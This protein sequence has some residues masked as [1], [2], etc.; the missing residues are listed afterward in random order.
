MFFN[1]NIFSFS[2][3]VCEF[4]NKLLILESVIYINKKMAEGST[5]LF[6]VVCKKEV[7][8][9][10]KCLICKEFVHVFAVKE[11]QTKKDLD[12]QFLVSFA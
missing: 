10:H 7:G 11:M 3:N 2:S 1:S 12:N 5:T 6:C 9:A 8:K 4:E